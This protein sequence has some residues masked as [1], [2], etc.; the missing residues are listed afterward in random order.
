MEA[1][2]IMQTLVMVAMLSPPACRLEDAERFPPPFMIHKAVAD[3]VEYRLWLE[4]QIL[5][6][7]AGGR[8]RLELQEALSETLALHAIH[9][10]L[11]GGIGYDGPSME[12]NPEAAKE[13]RLL[14]FS[15]F[16]ELVGEDVYWGSAPLP[17]P[18]PLWRFHYAN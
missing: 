13:Y 9:D 11:G 10:S 2:L 12:S 8:E 14:W 16:R 5:W 17:P 18:L 15:R 3:N 1:S 6:D 7:S 4:K